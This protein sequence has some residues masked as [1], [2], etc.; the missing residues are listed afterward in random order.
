ML[1]LKIYDKDDFLEKSVKINDQ[2][3]VE[4]IY[5]VD[6][7]TFF[8]MN[9]RNNKKHIEFKILNSEISLMEGSAETIFYRYISKN[10]KKNIE[11]PLCDYNIQLENN[12]ISN[13]N[14]SKN[15]IQLW[16]TKI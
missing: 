13:F 16:K 4:S 15:K 12:I 8:K 14:I 9:V 5:C 11:I 2:H 3:Q 6:K 7:N 1:W 10:G